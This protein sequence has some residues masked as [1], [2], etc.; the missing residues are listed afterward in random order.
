LWR[1]D[2]GEADGISP[3]AAVVLIGANNFGKLRWPE[4]ET[5]PGIEKIVADLHK[6]LPGTHILLIGVLPSIRNK[7]VDENTIE[8]NRALAARYRDG[9]DATFMDLSALFMRDGRVDA[10]KFL[11]P[12]LT[13]PGPPLHP[14]ATSQA[15]IAAAIE[16]TLSRWL[17][18]HPRP[19]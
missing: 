7:W 6:H 3:K 13:P 18:D 10:N 4:S 5:E 2:H 12:Q 16:P 15:A 14:N 1:I 9:H 19:P 11:D 17:G 8:L